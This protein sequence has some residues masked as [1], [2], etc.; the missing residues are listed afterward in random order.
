MPGT[1]LW[2]PGYGVSHT[3]RQRQCNS[4][5]NWQAAVGC[6]IC[7]FRP[8]RYVLN[9]I[10]ANITTYTQS[11]YNKHVTTAP[12]WNFMVQHYSRCVERAWELSPQFW[13]SSWSTACEQENFDI[14]TTIKFWF[15]SL[16][17]R[18][19]SGGHTSASSYRFD[20]QTDGRQKSV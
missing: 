10:S 17:P 13:I 8:G 6:V 4:C 2:L 9:N 19:L 12:Y 7:G 1:V 18:K 3:K 16:S 11:Y 20:S 14:F 15:T 5:G